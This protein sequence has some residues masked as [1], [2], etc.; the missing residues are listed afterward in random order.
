MKA[1]AIRHV[2]FEHLG[3]FTPVLAGRG[4]DV[5]YRDAGVDSLAP[6]R[7]APDLLIVLGGPIGAYE[8][9]AYPF[10]SDELRLI[11]RQLKAGKP[12]LGIC[13]GAQL[14]ARA[15]G[16]RVYPNKT[17]EIG[18]GPLTPTTEGLSSPLAP[19][20]RNS[21]Q[22]L[23]WHGDTFDLPEGAVRL[24]STAKTEN[25]AFVAGPKVLG[26]QFHIEFRNEEIERWLIGHAVEISAAGVEHAQLRTDT[27]R[28]GPGLER[29]GPDCLSGWLDLLKARGRAKLRV[30][31]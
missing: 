17:K 23:H 5:R 14:I 8:E 27:M 16:A 30:V 10:L 7:D 22:V 3:T 26:L 1:L 18:W 29:A 2:G 21:W 9:A 19:L 25:Q 24:G 15:M 4:Y 12:L 31:Q 11:E 13:L 6:E 28:W 20:G